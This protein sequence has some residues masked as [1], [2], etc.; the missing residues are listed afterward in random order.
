M[1]LPAVIQWWIDP[2][3]RRAFGLAPQDVFE[4]FV[5]GVLAWQPICAVPFVRTETMSHALVRFEP[6]RGVGNAL[7]VADLLPLTDPRPRCVRFNTRRAWTKN[8]L[9]STACHELGH[10]MG[11][12]H[13]R[14]GH[15]VMTA[16]AN[17]L[18]YVPTAAD[19]RALW[20]K[21]PELQP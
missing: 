12:G 4:A 20:K 6:G 1:T 21:Y 3:L 10:A 2:R 11:L 18:V 17:D 19:R 7:A 13:V 8:L 5:A 16:F 14:K 15:S 9:M